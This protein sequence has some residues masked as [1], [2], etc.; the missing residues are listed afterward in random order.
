MGLTAR[1]TSDQEDAVRE[2][3]MGTAAPIGSVQCDSEPSELG[4]LA[5][6]DPTVIAAFME[7]ADAIFKKQ[8]VA[9]HGAGGMGDGP[10][11]IALNPKPADFT[12]PERMGGVTDIQLLEIISA[13]KGTMPAFSAVLTPEEIQAVV[14]YVR[15]LSA[16]KTSKK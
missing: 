13:G 7:P 6:A 15:S 8:C 14:E 2:F 10:A 1:L 4:R 11:A 3:L 16:A 12:D 9:C 5:G